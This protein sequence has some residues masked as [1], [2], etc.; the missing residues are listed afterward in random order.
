MPAEWENREYQESW[1]GNAANYDPQGC[2]DWMAAQLDS[3]RPR[4][5]LD[6]GCGTG[7]GLLS[8]RRRFGCSLPVY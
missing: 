1:S 2:Y 7:E 5:V 3:V 6:V 4:R 8:L